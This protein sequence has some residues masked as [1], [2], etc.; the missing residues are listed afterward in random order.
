MIIDGIL[1]SLNYLP[2]IIVHAGAHLA[3]EA[4]AYERLGAEEVVWLEAD[5]DVVASMRERL[6]SLG[7]RGTRHH[8]LQALVSDRDGE[9][10]TF[11]RLSNGGQSSSL[12][13]PSELLFER[14]SSVTEAEAPL[15]L[16]AARLDT[17]L[18][19]NGVLARQPDV[20]VMDLQGAEVLAMRGAPRL[21]ATANFVEVEASLDSIYSDAP[22]FEEVDAELQALG[23]IRLSPVTLHCD[24]VYMK[25]FRDRGVDAARAVASAKKLLAAG[26]QDEAVDILRQAIPDAAHSYDANW[27]LSMALRRAGQTSEADAIDNRMALFKPNAKRLVAL[28][29]QLQAAWL[30]EPALAAL[31]EARSLDTEDDV[32]LV[33]L[34]NVL[35]DLA[36]Y[37]EAQRAFGEAILRDPDVAVYHQLRSVAFQASGNFEDAVVCAEA[38]CARDPDNKDFRVFLADMLNGLAA[39]RRRKGDGSGADAAAARAA[40]IREQALQA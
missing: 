14:Y 12:F 16:R 25:P 20:V 32:V 4:E 35:L 10:V 19:Q 40:E 11:H 7:Q 9:E 2:K 28:A 5:P 8:I 36:R 23:F 6:A 27:A 30:L 38:A 3:Q 22:L 17:L 13:A 33:H 31:Q 39:K 29:K 37:D 26:R 18:E 21:L 34:G 1:K 15:V 24:V